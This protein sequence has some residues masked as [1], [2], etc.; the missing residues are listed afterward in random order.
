MHILQ[1]MLTVGF[2]LTCE[3]LLTVSIVR[4]IILVSYGLPKVQSGY[5]QV[6]SLKYFQS[7]YAEPPVNSTLMFRDAFVFEKRLASVVDLPRMSVFILPLPTSCSLEA[8]PATKT[9]FYI[10]EG[11]VGLFAVRRSLVTLFISGVTLQKVR[12]VHLSRIERDIPSGGQTWLVGKP[13]HKRMFLSEHPRTKWWIFH[14][15]AWLPE[16]KYRWPE[17]QSGTPHTKK[18]GPGKCVDSFTFNL[19][20]L[21]M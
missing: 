8:V 5:Y 21:K 9:S 19:A 15:H 7:A 16:S 10:L 4:L 12:V 3:S 11:I 14:C 2:G 20:A 1:G 17:N 6:A 13:P 18:I